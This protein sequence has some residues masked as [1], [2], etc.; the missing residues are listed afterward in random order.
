MTL[1]PT[2]PSHRAA[3][4]HAQDLDLIAGN[5]GQNSYGGPPAPNELFLNDGSGVFTAVT[6][7]PITASNEATF[8][9]AW[10]DIDNDGDL[11]LIVGNVGLNLNGAANELYVNDG[12]GDFTAVTT[13]P[14][15]ATTGST[16]ALVWGDIDGDGV[17]TWRLWP[18]LP[19]HA[20][21]RAARA[22]HDPCSP[23][24][25]TST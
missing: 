24:R 7:S 6:T 22:A 19:A 16:V 9:L 11:D 8:S 25:R 2:A 18:T 20:G 1:T 17:R 13:S 15:T 5:C 23:H 14:I 21:A 3:T 10:G 12:S 4:P